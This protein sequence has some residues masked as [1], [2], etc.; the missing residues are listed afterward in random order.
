MNL[1]GSHEAQIQSQIRYSLGRPRN[2]QS[3]V[4]HANGAFTLKVGNTA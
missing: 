1:R 3:Q 4:A 2:R